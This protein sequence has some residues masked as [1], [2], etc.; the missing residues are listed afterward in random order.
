MLSLCDYLL[1]LYRHCAKNYSTLSMNFSFNFTIRPALWTNRNLII[2]K[3]VLH[4]PLTWCILFPAVVGLGCSS[5]V[6]TLCKFT[7]YLKGDSSR[8]LCLPSEYTKFARSW[9][10]FMRRP[11]LGCSA[12]LGFSWDY[13]KATLKLPC[14]LF[15]SLPPVP[16]AFS[17]SQASQPHRKLYF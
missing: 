11:A 6:S 14:T 8:K 7:L 17:K 16:T 9:P 10:L 13:S 3:Q 12:H 2:L 1:S 5:L 15:G 4:F